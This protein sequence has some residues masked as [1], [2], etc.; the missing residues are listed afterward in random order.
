MAA[1][2]LLAGLP[3][4]AA[5]QAPCP[6]A[7]DPCP[8]V[9]QGQ[10]GQR[11][12]GVLRFPQAVAIGP[13]GSVY[14][15]DQHSRVVSV[16]GPDGSFLREIGVPGTRPGELGAV[17]ALAT[18]P[19][20]TLFVAK[21][22]N[23]IDRFD[24]TGRLLASFGRSGT[25]PG[26]FRFGAGGGNDA[27]AGGGL[28]ASATHLFVADSGNDRIQR[29]NLDGSGAIELV[30]AGQLAYPK[31]VA[32]RGSRLLVADDQHHRV[33]AY[34]TG[35]RFLKELG[36]GQGAG[37][38][39]LANPYGVAAD[40]AGRTYVADNLNHRVV[41]FGTPPDY[42]Y[43]ARFGSFGTQPGRLAFVRALT[44]DAA[45]NVLVAN[46]ANDRIDVFN[47]DGRLLRSFGSSGRATGQFNQPTGVAADASGMR[48]VTD[49]TNGRVQLL[50]PAGKIVTVWG[51]PNPGPTILRRPVGV[52]FDAAGT[53]YA[54][55][56]RRARII[57]FSRQ[58]G[59][60]VRTIGS[61]GRGPGQMLDP[62][63]IAM[64]PGG[65]IVVADTGNRRIVRFGSGGEYRG[66]TTGLGAVRGVAITPDGQRTYVATENRILVLDPA[67]NELDRFGGT[68]SKL[69]KLRSPAGLAL[70]A[71]GTLW[72]AD[73]ANNRVQRF[74]PAGERLLT[75]GE[76]GTGP[77]QFTYPTGV[78]V[79]CT[80]LLTVTDQANNRVQQF[81][82]T[83]PAAAPCAALP[84]L[85]TPPPPKVPTLA[86]PPGPE[87]AASI[88]TRS[89]LLGS[90]SVAVRVRCDTPC[91]L[92]L[93]GALAE[94]A[95]ER[96]GTRRRKAVEVAL[97]GRRLELPP[98][99]ATTIR[100]RVPAGGAQRLLRA[101]RGRRGLALSVDLTAT[102]SS[103][104]QTQVALSRD[105][106]R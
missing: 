62:A 29:L 58:T 14:V 90:R 35:G 83:A 31:G 66:A 43:V 81:R 11:T 65:T 92:T 8:Y 88:L 22:S 102:S 53:L 16:F 85:G 67:G 95:G 42:P 70:D 80:G 33:V 26:E 13:D 12:G 96:R 19:D 9:E 27:G 49:A 51:S 6:G 78:T 87:V 36:R 47:R 77:G 55:D 69:G 86:P 82:L 44:T 106:T 7:A 75:L 61:Q 59:L 74:G 1:L 18:A 45:G 57:V 48:A 50:D 100:L 2:A 63:A 34:D 93:T 30:P 68:G 56:E 40:A 89:G 41:R 105:A 21:G 101:L 4:T 28:A 10:V 23:A 17:G 3:A 73:R 72:V 46:T 39:Q 79:D 54:L 15:G 38:G 97:S 104:E 76:R 5:A 32:V 37:P 98:A 84:P 71:A 103:G 64:T 99:R 52:A 60:P 91:A 94:R 25:G 20:G 24:P